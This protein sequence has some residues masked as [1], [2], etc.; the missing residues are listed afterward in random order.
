MFAECASGTRFQSDLKLKV[1]LSFG[2][3]YL[4]VITLLIVTTVRFHLSR[5]SEAEK[6]LFFNRLGAVQQPVMT[7][8]GLIQDQDQASFC[9]VFFFFL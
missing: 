3:I 1:S 4:P 5:A 8:S 9:D 7:E 6:S 2:F